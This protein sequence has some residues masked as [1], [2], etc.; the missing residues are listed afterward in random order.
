MPL[1]TG[2]RLFAQ[3]IVMGLAGGFPVY[4]VRENVDPARPVLEDA[5]RSKVFPLEL[6]HGC[7]RFSTG[8]FTPLKTVPGGTSTGAASIG[9]NNGAI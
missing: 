8:C 9:R 1:T 5:T 4:A 3:A 6:R 7:S 2:L